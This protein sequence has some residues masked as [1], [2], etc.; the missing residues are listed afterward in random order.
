MEKES[1]DGPVPEGVGL[2][3][4][5]QACAAAHVHPGIGW[6]GVPGPGISHPHPQQKVYPYLLR[7]VV[8]K[9]CG[10]SEIFNSD[11]GCQFTSE[12]SIGVLKASV[13]TIS[14]DRRRGH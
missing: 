2:P 9:K 6:Y 3:D 13:I 1:E 12:S 11:Q 4:Q 7:G 8:V 10:N 14:T 5:P